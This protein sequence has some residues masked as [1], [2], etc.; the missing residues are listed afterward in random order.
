MYIQPI[1]IRKHIITDGGLKTALKRRKIYSVSFLYVEREGKSVKINKK[2]ISNLTKCYSIAPLHYK[3]KDFFLVAAR[4]DRCI[5][6]D[7]EGNEVD[8]IWEQPGGVMSMVQV[9][10]SD[11]VFL[12]HTASILQMIQKKHRSFL[13]DRQKKRRNSGAWKHWFRFHM[14]TDLIL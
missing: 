13:S 1:R 11:G 4:T 2:I 8:T 5:L 7:L 3:G 10:G 6:F 14:Y 9:P 12:R